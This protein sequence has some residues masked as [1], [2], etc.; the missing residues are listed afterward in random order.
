[1]N[2]NK[3][4]LNTTGLILP[5]I[6][7]SDAGHWQSLWQASNSCFVRVQQRDWGN[8]VR[9]EWINTLE[10]SVAAVSGDIVL[11]AHS[12]GCLLIAHWVAQ[13]KLKVKGALLV[14]PPDSASADFPEQASGFYPFPL[15]TFVFPSIVVASSN[16]FYGDLVFAKSCAEAWGSHFKN[17]GEAGH[18]NTASGFGAWEEG[19]SLYQKLAT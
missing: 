2:H 17:I 14:A 11:V 10:E 9:K 8:P 15:N 12:L 4:A 7:D 3:A 5:G 1:M 13:T 18:I 16:D 19:F 6:G